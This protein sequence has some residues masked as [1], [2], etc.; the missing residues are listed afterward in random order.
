MM[1]LRLMAAQHDRLVRVA[2]VVLRLVEV[3]VGLQQVGVGSRPPSFS[4]VNILIIIRIL[5]I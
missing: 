2:M 4:N 1:I 3:M 5:S